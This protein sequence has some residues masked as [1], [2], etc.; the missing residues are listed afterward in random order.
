MS[1]VSRLL[2]AV[3]GLALIWIFWPFGSRDEVIQTIEPP[4]GHEG[5]IFTTPLPEDAPKPEPKPPASTQAPAK[6]I[7]DEPDGKAAEKTE[8][9]AEEK[10]AAADPPQQGAQEPKPKLKSMRYY[11]V[12]VRDGGTLEA[13]K[14]VITLQGVEAQPADKTCKDAK[15]RSWACGTGAR[16]ALTRLIRGRAVICKVPGDGKTPEMTARCSVS[17]TDLSLWMITQGWVKPATPADAEL[18]EAG[19]AARKKKIGVWR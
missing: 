12:M 5:R 14:I 16:A 15:G 13:G 8:E 6:Q 7:D 9:K 1:F 4:S 10:T 18:T 17:G 11:R 3:V 2:T 19:E